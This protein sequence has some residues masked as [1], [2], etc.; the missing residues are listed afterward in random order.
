MKAESKKLPK[1]QIE[2]TFELTEEEFKKYVGKAT[3]HLKSH[4]KVDGFRKGKVPNSMVEQ[5]V[6]KENLLA[7]AG[8]IAVRESYFNYVKE[9]KLEPVGNPEISITKIAQGSPFEFKA[10]IT[11]MPEIVLP[12]YKEIAKTVADK[13]FAVTEEEIQHAINHLQRSR[14]KMIPKDASEQAAKKD[15]VH[16]LYSSKDFSDGKEI[17]DQFVLGEGGFMPGFEDQIVGMKAGET[18]EFKA[19]FPK[20]APQKNLAGKES[21]FKVTLNS[22]HTME[23]PEVSDAWAKELGGFD[24]LVA[25]KESITKGMTEEKAE[26]EKQ[27]KRSEILEK[28]AEKTSI[29][30]PEAV[31]EYEKQSLLERFQRQITQQFKISFEE[32]L[33]SVKQTEE[34]IKQSFQ[35]EA[36]KRLKEFLILRQIGKDER[37]EVTAEELKAEVEK[38]LENYPAD[39][40]RQID[41]S[42]FNEYTE[43]VIYNEKVFKLLEDSSK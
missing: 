13:D 35:K 40:K 29:E 19:T 17:P 11:V 1:S 10:I 15:F 37:I 28:I 42:Q 5:Q 34:H 4:V 33:A 41:I 7:E 25:L 26:Q 24:T 6:G 31:V 36:E 14:A 32:Y 9:Q 16:I 18:K 8:D 22:V 43:G 12:D 38:A 21:D 2:I 39:Q 23:M 27:R 3:E 30:I 20:D